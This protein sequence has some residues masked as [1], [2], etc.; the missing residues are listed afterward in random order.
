VAAREYKLIFTGTMGAGKTTAIAAISE[1]PPITT[2]VQNTDKTRHQK[3]TTTTA[4]DYGEVT[5]ADGDKLRLYGTP[6]QERFDFMWKILSKGA[7]GVVILVDNSRPDPVADL[8]TYLD[9][10]ADTVKESRAVVGV[11]RT[12]IHATPTLEQHHAA[13]CDLGVGVPLFSV[14][15]RQ[16]DDVLLLVDV[17]LNQ[18]EAV[19]AGEQVPAMIASRGG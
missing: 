14:D 19:T 6:G 15:V 4:L 1:I 3:A 8:R 5:L 10:F 18:I 11:G 7:L 12:E 2:E 9:A 13:L 16:R 17:L